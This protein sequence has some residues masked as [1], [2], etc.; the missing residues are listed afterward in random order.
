VVRFGNVLGSRGSVVPQ[1]KRQIE[2]GGPITITHPDM[3]RFFMTIPEAVHLV[4]Q[5]G[6]MAQGGE[7]FVLNMGQPVRITQ[8]AEDL[9]SLSGAVREEVQIVYTGLRPGEKLEEQLWEAD[10]TVKPTQ[11]ADIFHVSEP[12][13]RNAPDVPLEAFAEAARRG[14]REHIE[15]L[16][17]EQVSTYAPPR[18]APSPVSAM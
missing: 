11:H 5:A 12:S 3:T 16:L 1:F 8:L 6:G 17:A 14:N 2:A 13:S 10:A 4:V 7:L 15:A 18:E 9:I